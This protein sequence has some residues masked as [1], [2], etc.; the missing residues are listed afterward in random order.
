MSF[1]QDAHW[2]AIAVAM[3][4]HPH[5]RAVV[6]GRVFFINRAQPGAAHPEWLGF[7]GTWHEFHFADGYCAISNDVVHNGEV[8]PAY[9]AAIPD[10][11]ILV[12]TSSRQIAHE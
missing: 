12:R 9:R 11:A 10:N 1:D 7:G 6:D 4:A 8:P 5:G 3:A 2:A